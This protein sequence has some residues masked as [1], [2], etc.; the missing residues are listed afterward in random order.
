MLECPDPCRHHEVGWLWKK[1]WCRECGGYYCSRCGRTNV[2]IPFCTCE[3]EFG[4]ATKLGVCSLSKG[5]SCCSLGD[6]PV[7][8]LAI[9]VPRYL[10]AL[11]AVSVGY[12]GVYRDRVLREL[13]EALGTPNPRPA[14]LNAIH[15]V[16]AEICALPGVYATD[17]DVAWAHDAAISTFRYYR[18]AVRRAVPA[19]APVIP[20]TIRELEA[21]AGL[22][23]LSKA[24]YVMCS[25]PC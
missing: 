13:A 11:T 24:T 8:P 6:G 14:T 9:L 22:L 5:H 19:T 10:A 15:A 21:A 17:G 23:Q 1:V 20:R 4:A 18:S 12:T 3:L 2:W 16:L 25:S 7:S